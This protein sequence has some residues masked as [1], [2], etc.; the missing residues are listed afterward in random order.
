MVGA[1]SIPTGRVESPGSEPADCP[2]MKYSSASR[3]V[4]GRSHVL[5]FQIARAASRSLRRCRFGFGETARRVGSGSI[6]HA[7]KPGPRVH[8]WQAGEAEEAGYNSGGADEN[9]PDPL[10]DLVPPAAVEAALARDD[11]RLRLP[12]RPRPAVEAVAHAPRV[13]PATSRAGRPTP[14]RRRSAGPRTRPARAAAGRARRNRTSG[15]AAAARRYSRAARPHSS[16]GR[17]GMSPDSRPTPC[18]MAGPGQSPM[19]L[20]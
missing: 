20:S 11:D 1:P 3:L 15:S 16:N 4:Q 19:V 8:H 12:R 5:A 6:G 13:P 10:P 9:R 2:I 14:T 18:S 7:A 17:S